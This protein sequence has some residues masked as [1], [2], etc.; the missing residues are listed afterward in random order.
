[1]SNQQDKAMAN[2]PV[3]YTYH[4]DA[5][6]VQIPMKT[7]QMMN[8]LAKELQPLA[9]LVSTFEQIGQEHIANGTLIP[10]FQGD[11][12]PEMLDGVPKIVN[13][14]IQ[15]KLKDEFWEPKP[16]LVNPDGSPLGAVHKLED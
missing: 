11:I 15:Y 10:V 13:G 5:E 2:M 4:K 12:E 14:Q 8:A 3:S 16:Q 9:M 7:W 1:M 6:S